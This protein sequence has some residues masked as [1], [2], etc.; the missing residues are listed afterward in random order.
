VW[1][2]QDNVGTNGCQ[3]LWSWELVYGPLS[4]PLLSLRR[5]GGSFR[6][7]PTT[8]IPERW[9]SRVPFP[10]SAWFHSAFAGAFQKD[11]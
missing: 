8:L 1:V 7:P 4:F 11:R 2:G 6:Y 9:L 10:A 3:E 5:A